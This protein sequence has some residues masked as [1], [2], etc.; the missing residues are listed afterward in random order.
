MPI[1]AGNVIACITIASFPVYPMLGGFAGKAL[2]ESRAVQ[3]LA[4][5]IGGI[6]SVGTAAIG[7]IGEQVSKQLIDAI[8]L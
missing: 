2:G 1:T 5:V 6:T 4:G 3:S 8:D 7:W